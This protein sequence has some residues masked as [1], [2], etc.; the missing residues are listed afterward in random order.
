MKK[1]ITD[2]E[3]IGQAIRRRRKQLGYTQSYISDFTGL[4]VSFLSDLENG[5][6]TIE[7]EKAISVA[8]ILGMNLTVEPR[9]EYEH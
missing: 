3:T 4:S 7:L 1:N 9:G 5:K 8:M 2:A 6:K